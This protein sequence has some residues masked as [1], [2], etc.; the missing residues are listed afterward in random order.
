MDRYI[1]RYIKLVDSKYSSS[2]VN[3][4]K[5]MPKLSEHE[6][7]SI[8][9][10]LRNLQALL[11]SSK[12]YEKYLPKNINLKDNT[13]EEV[14][15]YIKTYNR[16]FLIRNNIAENFFINYFNFVCIA[17]QVYIPNIFSLKTKK[18]VVSF[19]IDKQMRNELDS[20]NSRHIVY[21]KKLTTNIR[22]LSYDKLHEKI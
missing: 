5:L 7:Y 16:Y 22:L 4:Y 3:I 11:I 12:N 19:W 8:N 18:L 9:L 6:R 1:K 2:K 14:L 10:S 17:N 15:N 13:I 20:L 21:S